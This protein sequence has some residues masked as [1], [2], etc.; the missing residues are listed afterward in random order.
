MN[1]DFPSNIP[2][3][4]IGRKLIENVKSWGLVFFERIEILVMERCGQDSRN[5]FIS[6]I[7]CIYCKE[8]KYVQVFLN[9]V[10]SHAKII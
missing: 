6:D 1:F 10:Y 3:I 8:E 2:T 4:S 9:C 5:I 7:V